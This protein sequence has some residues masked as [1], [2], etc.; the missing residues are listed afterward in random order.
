MNINMSSIMS[1]T[2]AFSESSEGKRRMEACIEKYIKDGRK[3]TATGDKII[4]EDMMYEAA[5]K[6]ITVLRA[7]ANEMDLPDSVLKHF[8]SLSCSRPIKIPDGSTEIY[9]Y[10]EDDLHRDSLDDGIN[11]YTGEGINNIIALLNNGTHAKGYV[12][13]YWEGHE[14][15]G[16]SIFRAGS[17][18]HAKY[19]WVRSKKDRDPMR[20]IQ[21]AIIDFNGNYGAEYGVT[22]IAGD[23]YQ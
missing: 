5:G 22:A 16:E 8:D 17:D 21:Q 2:K 9:V 3:A 19:A 14:P 7:T 11:G 12:Y 6:F 15:T 1:K 4:T 18:L 23:Q 20:F 10:F 13:G